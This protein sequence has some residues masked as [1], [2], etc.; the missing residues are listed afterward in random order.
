MVSFVVEIPLQPL[1][2]KYPPP[3]SPLWQKIGSI[4]VNGEHT[5]HSRLCLWWH[6]SGSDSYNWPEHWAGRTLIGR[7]GAASLY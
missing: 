2:C 1:L 5:R 4:S 7:R 6:C 3:P